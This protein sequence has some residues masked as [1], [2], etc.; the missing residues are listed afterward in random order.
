MWL[1]AYFAQL[2]RRYLRSNPYEL[3]NIYVFKDDDTSID[4]TDWLSDK[5][6]ITLNLSEP[7]RAYS[8]LSKP[9]QTYQNI[10]E[11]I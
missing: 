1:A 4:K 8:R 11:P 9:I 7:I 2:L 6:Q 10:F 5:V 3:S